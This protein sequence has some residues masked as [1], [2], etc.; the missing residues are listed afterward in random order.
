MADDV[1][2][3]IENALNIIVS[4]T[5]QSGNMKMELKQTIFETVSTLRKLIVKLTDSR[6]SK[7]IAT[8][9][10]EARVSKMNAQID[11]SRGRNAKVHGAPPLTRHQEQAGITARD[12]PPSGG[13]NR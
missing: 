6:Y 12:V 1:C 3:G 10:L 2:E 13:R 9:K 4:T 11:T 5:E 7:N 8:G